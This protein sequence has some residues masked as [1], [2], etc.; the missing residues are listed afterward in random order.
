MPFIDVV[1]RGAR[2]FADRPALLFA[3]RAFDYRALDAGIDA[4]AARL[5]AL[6]AGP[7]DRV[8]LLLTNGPAFVAAFYAVLRLG[9]IAV[10]LAAA[11][12]PAQLRAQLD[13]AGVRLLLTCDALAAAADRAVVNARVQVGMVTDAWLA[14]AATPAARP[15]LAPDL[16]AAILYTSGTTGAQKGVTLSRRALDFNAEATVNALRL[17]PEDRVLGCLPLSHSFSLTAAMHTTFAACATLVVQPEFDAAATAAAIAAH[18]VTVLPAVPPVFRILLDTAAPA[19]LASLRLCLSAA[20]RLPADTAAGW[21]ARFGGVIHE[22]YGCTETS[23]TCFNH[24]LCYRPGSV[25]TPL[26]GV[27]LAVVD[28]QGRPCAP[29]EVGEVQVRCDGVMLGYWRRDDLTAAVLKDGWYRTGDLGCV[30]D[31]GYLFLTDRLSDIINT[32]GR[33]VLPSDVEAV[34]LSHPDVAEAA[35]FAGPNALLGADVR[36]AVVLKPGRP[37]QPDALADLCR[38]EL[39]D[40]QCPRAIHRLETLPKA[41]SGKVLKREL[42]ERAAAGDLGGGLPA[43]PAGAA[44]PAPAAGADAPA[45]TAERRRAIAEAIA[46]VLGTQPAVDADLRGLG[47]TSLKASELAVLLE[48][49]AG[50]ALPVTIAFQHPTLAA[51]QAHLAPAEDQVAGA[52]SEQAR[53]QRLSDAAIARAPHI[54]SYARLDFVHTPYLNFTVRPDYRSE[55]ISTDRHGFRVSHDADGRVDADGWFQRPH[56]ALAVGNSFMFGWGASAD[57][58]TIPSLLNARTRLCF[59]NVATAGANSM[60]DV[61]STL[62]FLADA[63]LILLG[64]G[65]SNLLRALEYEPHNELFGGLVGREF[66]AFTRTL[67]FRQVLELLGQSH[68]PAAALPPAGQ[69]AAAVL[70]EAMAAHAE[71]LARWQREGWSEAEVTRRFERALAHQRRDLSLLARAKPDGARLLFAM[72][73]MAMLAKPPHALTPE[74]E[75]LFAVHQHYNTMWKQVVEPYAERLLP[76][77]MDAVAEHCAALGVPY[78]DLNQLDYDGWCFCDQGHLTDRGNRIV[79]DFLANWLDAAGNEG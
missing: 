54:D 78:T 31:D 51:L 22:A 1:A 73:P 69:A 16:P 79:A 9:A 5:D 43:A 40:W 62:P 3:D 30:D 12:A 74:E 56:R 8:A 26:T 55:V 66:F 76:A 53:L 47:L 57:A 68:D 2:L 64:G 36:A 59:L 34:L 15:E 6:G 42:K 65:L 25:G 4:V 70:R 28:D 67:D 32:G 61:I 46:S 17:V 21:A 58:E 77:F 24:R 50:R 14:P 75:G 10:P 39:P 72:Q 60:Q 49:I 33:K 52:A 20:I 63:E 35:A 71:G 18:A 38:V 41:K 11:A 7:G 37:W 29:G 23:M 48:V 27:E 45:R 19:A 44:G 13:D